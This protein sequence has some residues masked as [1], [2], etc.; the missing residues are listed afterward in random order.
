MDFKIG[1]QDVSYDPE[2]HTGQFDFDFF[3]DHKLSTTVSNKSGKSDDPD[4]NRVQPEDGYLTTNKQHDLAMN[5][6]NGRDRVLSDN[7]DSSS[8]N[9][10]P[11]TGSM[12]NG[13][14]QWNNISTSDD[15][16]SISATSVENESSQEDHS[17]TSATVQ[18]SSCLREVAAEVATIEEGLRRIR[19]GSCSP[20]VRQR[21]RLPRPRS[22]CVR[23]KRWSSSLAEAALT[24]RRLSRLPRRRSRSSGSSSSDMVGLSESGDSDAGGREVRSW[25]EVADLK[26]GAGA[27]R[28]SSTGSTRMRVTGVSARSGTGSSLPSPSP[29]PG[30][31]AHSPGGLSLL[32]DAVRHLERGAPTPRR[33]APARPVR[34]P[35]RHNMSFTNDRVREIDRANQILLRKI[36]AQ[37]RRRV[38]SSSA[39]QPPPSRHGCTDQ[40]RRDNLVSCH[41]TE[42]SRYISICCWSELYRQLVRPA[43]DG[44]LAS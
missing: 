30:N 5:T 37:Q 24:T 13:H 3:D 33:T 36:V 15:H 14:Q 25:L 2:L 21:T 1:L 42:I 19:V 8:S 27:A 43:T 10:R 7:L 35:H 34:A 41:T 28:L 32:A 4:P 11:P 22:S 31:A 39:P 9:G 12:C 23:R 20:A 17:L 44:Q 18:D 26:A 29:P 40:I 38:P 16:S 6:G